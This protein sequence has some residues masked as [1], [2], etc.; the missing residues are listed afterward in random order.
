M[1]LITKIR[2]RF[3]SKIVTLAGEIE[4]DSNGVTEE[5]EDSVASEMVEQNIGFEYI[6]VV[7]A[8]KILLSDEEVAKLQA[9]KSMVKEVKTVTTTTDEKKAKAL[10]EAAKKAKEEEVKTEEVV[11]TT[12]DEVKTE[13]TKVEEK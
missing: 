4:V 11:T 1:K 10:A 9:A 12:T 5:I 2:T 8:T 13:E 3:N 7:E 6:P